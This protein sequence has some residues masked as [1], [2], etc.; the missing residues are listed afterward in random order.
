M[1]KRKLDVALCVADAGL[2]SPP[3]PQFDQLKSLFEDICEALRRESLS[4]EDTTQSQSEF[5]KDY[6]E[7]LARGLWPRLRSE[8]IEDFRKGFASGTWSWKPVT[9]EVDDDKVDRLGEVILGPIYTCQEYPWPEGSGLPMAPLIQLDLRKASEI[10]QIQLGD[11]LLQVWMPHEVF[12]TALFIR[13][14]PRATIDAS[15]LLPAPELPRELSPFQPRIEVWNDALEKSVPSS[16]IQITGYQAKRYTTQIVHPIQA[17]Y[18][19]K[20]L[21][22]V[23]ET[24]TMVKEFDK[25]LKPFLKTGLKGFCPSDCHLFGTFYRV[26][27]AADEVPKPLFCFESDELGFSWGQ[28]GNA[29]LFYV[30]ESDGE[31]SFSFNWSDG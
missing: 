17:N 28:C 9:K 26:Q 6:R 25:R 8:F 16:A 29:Q 13:V 12:S 15:K 1:S 31:V 30:I 11:G 24:Q 20:V 19:V 21:T 23:V 14:V 18:S 22:S 10:G 27:Y 5:I 4:K 3:P 7:G 2:N